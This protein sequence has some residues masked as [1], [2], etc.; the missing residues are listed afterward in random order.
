[1]QVAQRVLIGGN[2]PCAEGSYQIKACWHWDLFTTGL[3]SFCCWSLGPS[4]STGIGLK[5]A[6]VG[7]DLT[8]VDASRLRLQN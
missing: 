5:V 6:E 7:L 2:V 4:W 8:A 1:M 3:Q